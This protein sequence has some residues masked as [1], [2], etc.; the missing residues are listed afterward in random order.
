M[1]TMERARFRHTASAITVLAHI[2]GVTACILMLVW[3]LHYRGGLAYDSPNP[4]L[5]FNVRIDS[6]FFLL[7]T[8][9][10]A[11]ARCWCLSVF[12]L[13]WVDFKYI[14]KF[15][16]WSSRQLHSL[17]EFIM[18]NIWMHNAA[19]HVANQHLSR[20]TPFFSQNIFNFF[21]SMNIFWAAFAC[22]QIELI[23]Y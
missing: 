2:F 12:K 5:I 1:D 7:R 4:D 15:Y 22:T 18:K 14:F 23:Y 9:L 6:F 11:W 17:V 20:V 16:K 19:Q 21:I 3:L 10:Y 13:D 8:P